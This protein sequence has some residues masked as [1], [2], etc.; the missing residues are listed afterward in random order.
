M[1]DKMR[2]V[3]EIPNTGLEETILRSGKW[4]GDSLFGRSLRNALMN[5]TK[6]EPILDKIKCDIR[7]KMAF[8]SFNEGYVLY[9]DIIEV[10]AKY[11]AEAESEG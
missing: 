10:F 11:K 9:D 6:E 8:N 5:F 1:N 3:I 7:K 2:I 4:E